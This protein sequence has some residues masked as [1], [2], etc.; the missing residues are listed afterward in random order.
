M[1]VVHVTVATGYYLLEVDTSDASKALLT[2]VIRASAIGSIELHLYE[3]EKQLLK[4]SL[5]WS[6]EHLDK[7]FGG[8]N[9]SWVPYQKWKKGGTLTTE[10]I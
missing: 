2:R 8:E 1:S 6:N 9:Y 7:L 4:A 5:S 10:D 3:I